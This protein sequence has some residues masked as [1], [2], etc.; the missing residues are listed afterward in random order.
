LFLAFQSA[1]LEFFADGPNA[2]E[3]A[4]AIE[5]ADSLIVPTITLFEVF[6]RIRV[7]R[8]ADSALEAIAFM[9]RGRPVDLDADLAIEAADL[10]VDLKLPLADSIILATARRHEAVLWTQD[11]D[12]EGIPGVEYRRRRGRRRS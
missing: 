12:F 8:D 6:K 2:G 11:S 10:S 5:D 1:W 3:F 4:A 9:Q 7:Q